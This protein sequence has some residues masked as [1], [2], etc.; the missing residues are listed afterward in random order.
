MTILPLKEEVDLLCDLLINKYN[1]SIQLLNKLYNNDYRDQVNSIFRS[2]NKNIEK[3]D[4]CKLVIY[5]YGPNLFS[6]SDEVKKELRKKLLVQLEEKKLKELFY[7]H[8]NKSNNVKSPS[9]MIMPLVNKS[10]YSNGIW[11]IDFVEALGIPKIFAGADIRVH[12]QLKTVEEVSPRSRVPKLRN[13]QIELKEK[14][15]EVLNKE[16][17]KTR[18]MLTLPTGGGKT[19]VA[20][21]AFIEWMM[22]RFSEGKFFIWVAQSSELCEQAVQCIKSLWEETEYVEKLK[23][24]RYFEGREIPSNDVLCGG[25]I[26]ANIHQL[27]NRIKQNDEK[28]LEIIKNT[29]AMVIDE[30]HRAISWMYSNLFDKAEELC[31]GDLFPICGLS[32]TPGRTGINK[33]EETTKLVNR[34]Q[35][36][37]LKPDL[38]KEYEN[39]PLK[40]FRDKKYLAKANHI[41][42]RSGL[43]FTLTDKEINSIDPEKG[44]HISAL[45]LKRL[46]K[47]KKRN[48]KIVNRLCEIPV[49][50]STIVYTCTVEQAEFLCSI[51]NYNGRPSAL[52]TPGYN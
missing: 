39:D 18:C 12:E 45:F 19:R 26:V 23:I 10:W 20:V 30:A 49:G 8:Y 28:L 37:L 38:G 11:P 36:Y 40:Y 2:F 46:S 29:G 24:Y 7:K 31:G 42:F 16:G 6:G 27:H 1:I 17:N 21:E 43:E 44:D 41:V 32:A 48:Y 4:I 50:K 3:R 13:F 52:L 25:V 34:F 51:M 35:C 33:D 15:L 9:H 47:N 22:P 5:K 14:L